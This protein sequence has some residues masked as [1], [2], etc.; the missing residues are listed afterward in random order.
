MRG[1]SLFVGQERGTPVPAHTRRSAIR[2][3]LLIFIYAERYDQI[4]IKYPKRGNSELFVRE[5]HSILK[6]IVGGGFF[7]YDQG[8]G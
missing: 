7:G 1:Q 6:N 5:R 3:C 2:D 4:L 8:T